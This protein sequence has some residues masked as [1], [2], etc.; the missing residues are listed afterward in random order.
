[1]TIA[2]HHR[3]LMRACAVLAL[4]G[5]SITSAWAQMDWGGIIGTYGQEEAV[6]DA[7]R[8]STGQ[9]DEAAPAPAPP[10]PGS[11]PKTRAQCAKLRTWAAEGMRDTRLPPL[12]GLCRK[13]GY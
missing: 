5:P 2:S 9:R 8:E 6:S 13:L 3:T 10:R 7:A 1:M 12:L 11:N 4:A